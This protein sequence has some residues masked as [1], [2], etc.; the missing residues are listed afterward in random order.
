MKR[1]SRVLVAAALG[2][3]AAPPPPAPV[4]APCPEPAPGPT[5]AAPS[6]TPA[7]APSSQPEP[8]PT[9]PPPAASVAGKLG[10]AE[11][12]KRKPEGGWADA[13]VITPSGDLASVSRGQLAIYARHDGTVLESSNICSPVGPRAMVVL[14]DK[15]VMACSDRVVEV[16]LP[17]LSYQVRIKGVLASYDSLFREAAFGGDK[18]VY[19]HN[20]GGL[21]V[22]STSTWKKLSSD[23]LAED[24]FAEPVAVSRDGKQYTVTN[25]KA[26]TVTLFAGGRR[27]KIANM[28]EVIGFSPDGTRLF[29]S[30]GSFKAGD[31]STKDGSLRS[32]LD[33]GSWLTEAHY[34]GTD[35][36]ALGGSDGLV[37]KNLK[38]GAEQKLVDMTAETLAVSKDGRL[39][40]GADRGETIACYAKGAIA[41]SAYKP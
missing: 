28:R 11:L 26:G 20:D 30:P 5:I 29:G 40:C 34:F 32:L 38:T 4:P 13:S 12:W 33:T 31:V 16:T 9:P 14:R 21:E 25:E 35:M 24:T 17:G 19:I 1:V 36:L 7:P 37:V 41:K 23:K 18:V 10:Y 6:V 2:G 3:C 27:K 8:T 15:I 39:I 22:Y